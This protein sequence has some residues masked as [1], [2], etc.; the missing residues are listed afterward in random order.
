MLLV[1]LLCSAPLILVIRHTMHSDRHLRRTS[2]L[3]WALLCTCACLLAPTISH[4]RTRRIAAD[5][6]SRIAL[7]EGTLAIATDASAVEDSL[8]ERVYDSA[9]VDD[10]EVCPDLV[11]AD[12]SQP[13][14][15]FNYTFLTP[16]TLK[17]SFNGSWYLIDAIHSNS[18][19]W[20][21]QRVVCK[22][23]ACAG[24][25]CPTIAI[26]SNTSFVNPTQPTGQ[27]GAYMRINDTLICAPNDHDG[28]KCPFS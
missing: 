16:P 19:V 9:S 8:F 5:D 15:P 20:F 7:T 3:A 14:P 21:Y 12:P 22:Y 13:T 27:W 10:V 11:I 26:L 6:D 18:P 4:G 17:P 2:V 25:G 28:N 24:Y 1:A 23:A